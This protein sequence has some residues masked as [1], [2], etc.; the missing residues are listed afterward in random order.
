MP[1]RLSAVL[2][3][4][5]AACSSSLPTPPPSTPPADRPSLAQTY[6]PSGHMAAGDVFVH[7]F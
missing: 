3:L 4:I 6:R 2:A 5:G 1:F 7:L